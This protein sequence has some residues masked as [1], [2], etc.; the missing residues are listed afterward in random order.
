[1][2]VFI[3]ITLL[4]AISMVIVPRNGYAQSQWTQVLWNSCS[5]AILWMSNTTYQAEFVKLALVAYENKNIWAW[6]M[7]FTQKDLTTIITHAKCHCCELGKK[8]DVCTSFSCP[9]KNYFA[10]STH[11]FD[12]LVDIGMKKLDWDKEKCDKLQIDCN[13]LWTAWREWIDEE[14]IRPEWAP[15]RLIQEKFSQVWWDKESMKENTWR[16]LFH[17]YN[18]M[19]EQAEFLA[20][21]TI[22]ERAPTLAVDSFSA[23]N[24]RWWCFTLIDKRYEQEAAFVRTMIVLKSID[25]VMSNLNSYLYKYSIKTRLTWLLSKFADFDWCIGTVFKKANG[26]TDLCK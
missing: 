20:Q 22:L 15:A 16:T 24:K 21:N 9:V 23:S 8:L 4:S 18:R 26:K 5:N 19:C 10:E 6:W 2:K 17:E 12:H 25:F 11:L 7:F 13:E 1:M 3:G 14:G